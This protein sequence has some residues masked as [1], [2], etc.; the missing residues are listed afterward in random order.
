MSLFYAPSPIQPSHPSGQPHPHAQ[1]LL[2]G[3][4]QPPQN[5]SVHEPLSIDPLQQPYFYAIPENIDKQGNVDTEVILD[6]KGSND[7]MRVLDPTL[8][9]L[10]LTMFLM[11]TYLLNCPEWKT[12]VMEE[13][14]ALEKNKN[15]EIFDLRKGHKI[16]GCKWMFT[17]KYKVDGTIDRHKV[18]LAVKRFTQ[19]YEIDYSET[20]SPVAKLSTIRVLLSIAVNKDW[21]LYQLDVK[22]A[23]LNGGLK[24]E[25]Y[26]C[27]PPRF[28]AKFN[29]Q[30]YKLRMW[31]DLKKASPC[32]RENTPFVCKPRQVC[33]D[34]IL[35]TLLLNSTM[36]KKQSVV[37]KSSVEVKYQVMSLGIREELWLQK[38]LSDLH[39][40]CETP[41]KLLCDNKAAT[42]IA[43]PVQHDRTKHVEIDRHFIKERFDSENICIL[44]PFEPTGC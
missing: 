37:F 15:W 28:E 33:W 40:E 41:L 3:Y 38:V 6:G 2:S 34:V 19:T 4:G 43:N 44:Y 21:P 35:L 27:L 9:T 1:H 32:L 5:L 20:F 24:E 18:R 39:Q 31:P 36:R 30:V 22:N 23:F 14:K 7:E 25:V 13:I 8:S 11:R 42:S 16:V 10:L 12:V 17:L 29:I 26:I